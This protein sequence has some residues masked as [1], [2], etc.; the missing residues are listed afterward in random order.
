MSKHLSS[1]SGPGGDATGRSTSVATTARAESGQRAGA[2]RVW[3]LLWACTALV[4][5][6]VRRRL[7]DDFAT[8]PPRFALMAELAQV[9]D[10]LRM[11][12]LSQRLRVAAGTVTTLADQLEREGM[13]LRTRSS[14][15]RRV[16]T[17]A[18]TPAGRVALAAMAADHD[19][20]LDALLS[21]VPAQE[22][23]A[24][25]ANLA[26]LERRLALRVPGRRPAKRPDARLKAPAAGADL[27]L[28][29]PQRQP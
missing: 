21:E 26:A 28:C 15:D 14:T 24:L 16:Q 20:W 11:G 7:H 9:P 22:R 18:L 23:E 1:Y 4:E 12:Q 29:W 2:A 6:E 25:V 17:L 10:G 5:Q 3:N 19:R 27:H 13:V 8:S